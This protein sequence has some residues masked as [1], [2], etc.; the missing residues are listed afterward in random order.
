MNEIKYHNLK[1]NT[2]LYHGTVYDFDPKDIRTPCWLSLE[3]NQ[4]H[5]H[6][7]YRHYGN[8]NGKILI[9]KVTDKIDSIKLID[10][11]DNGDIRMYVN[12][13]G[14][15]K[16]AKRI[17]KGK[18][19][20]DILGYVNYPEQAEIMLCNN[21]CIEFIRSEKVDLSNKVQ[22]KR[23]DLKK[24]ESWRMTVDKKNKNKCCLIM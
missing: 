1:K 2:Y 8:K 22:Y 7:S 18:Y 15:Y 11:S 3:K 5:N 4:A 17:K 16:L 24:K 12:G 10:I 13:N 14:N 20:Q 19:G 6:I 9:Y 21:Y 23:V